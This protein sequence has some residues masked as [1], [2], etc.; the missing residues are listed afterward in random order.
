MRTCRCGAQAPAT[1]DFCDTCG[2]PLR[3][4]AVRRA[5][6]LDWRA[7]A[8]AAG[9]ALGLLAVGGVFGLQQLTAHPA[10]AAHKAQ[11][12]VIVVRSTQPAPRPRPAAIAA[13]AP[14]PAPALRPP[15]PAI[16][17]RLA[18][19]R[20]PAQRPRALTLVSLQAEP[21]QTSARKGPLPARVYN[22]VWLS[23]P[24]D[25]EL[26]QRYPARARRAGRRGAAQIECIVGAEG[27]LSACA[28][29]SEQPSGQGF[30]QAALKLAP[31]YQAA[32]R[33]AAGWP[34]AGYR[35]R[36]PVEWR[37]E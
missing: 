24:S 28:V 29:I 19:P 21:A 9:A 12:A 35:V 16:R 18:R 17:A 3:L 30:G 36:V 7:A 4:G 11:S 37:G 26:A 25:D 33:S 5:R 20:T 2:A 15:Q 22:P 8:L 31:R 32:P 23:Q 13:A 27:G 1:A 34:V 6:W 10:P 14:V